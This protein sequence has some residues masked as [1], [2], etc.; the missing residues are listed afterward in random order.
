MRTATVKG[1]ASASPAAADHPPRAHVFFSDE[2]EWYGPDLKLPR[3]GGRNGT[4]PLKR[5]R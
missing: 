5:R 2:A 4:P 1:A 3:F